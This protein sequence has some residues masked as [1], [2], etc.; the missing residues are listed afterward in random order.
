MNAFASFIILGVLSV[1][2]RDVKPNCHKE[3]HK[4]QHVRGR[5]QDQVPKEIVEKLNTFLNT[6]LASCHI[7]FVFME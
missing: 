2:S 7:M 5:F 3:G 6:T 1:Y 4:L